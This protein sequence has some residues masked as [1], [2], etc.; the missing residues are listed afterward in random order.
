MRRA[1]HSRWDR[2]C[3]STGC[4]EHS[5]NALG[6]ER[7]RY[8]CKNEC[9]NPSDTRHRITRIEVVRI[10]AQKR[11]DE[12][13]GPLIQDPWRKL[14]CP[15]S[16]EGCQVEFSDPDFQSAGRE[17]AYYVRAIQEPTLAINAGGLRCDYDSE[18]NCIKTHPCYGDYRTP[19]DDDCLSK[20][21]ERAW[22]SPIYV[23]E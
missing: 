21:E 4:P 9:Y 14:D 17:V 23:S 16:R 2:R 8:V 22:S 15:D 19:F 7:L 10:E 12:P 20:N 18:G 11:K 13:V 1:D 6:P 5:L 3:G